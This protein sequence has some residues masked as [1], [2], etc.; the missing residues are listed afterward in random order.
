MDT[1]TG[2]STALRSAER[3]Y[4]GLAA[5]IA[6]GDQRGYDVQRKVVGAAEAD[7]KRE[8]SVLG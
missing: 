3:A 1:L 6:R 7:V 2:L 5:A 8:T 4:A